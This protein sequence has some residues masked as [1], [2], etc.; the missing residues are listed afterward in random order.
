MRPKPLDGIKVLD[1]TRLL[2]G[3]MCTLH[4]A[5]MGAD[6][7]KIEDPHGGDYVR[8]R[9]PL[10]QQNS[11]NFLALN[12]NKRSLKLDLR[13]NKGREI[14]LALARDAEVIVDQFRPGVVERLGIG[15]AA[16][17]ALNPRIVYCAIT[18]YGQD[19]PYRDR[20]GHDVNYCSIAG[21]SDQIGPRDGAPVVPNFQIGD[22][23]GGSLAGV[24]G[25]LAAL[26]DAQRSGQGRYVD[27]AMTDCTLAHCTALLR[28]E[29]SYGA[30]QPRGN[31]YLSGGLPCYAFYETEDGRHVSLGAL[32]DKFWHAFCEGVER[33]DLADK[34]LAWGGE[35]DHVREQVA[36]VF[37]S[38]PLNYWADFAERVDCCLTP[39]LTL[40][41]ARENP[42]LKARGMFVRHEHPVDGP[43][44]QFAFPVKFSDFAF[45]IDRPAPLYGEHSEEVVEGL[46]YDADEIASLKADGVI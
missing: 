36:A 17:R 28:A 12:R 3:P 22:L 43:I 40:E 21:L 14:F 8:W 24:M 11:P 2:P 23:L 30:T 25:I 46:G 37:K 32:E 31:D 29:Q 7:L 1:L 33:P 9:P 26:L 34:G 38:Q 4:L 42:Q 5:D 13:N 19:G 16:V 39:V 35:A 15:Y 45:S 10:R 20:A 6:V 44:E 18:G 27:V 41:E